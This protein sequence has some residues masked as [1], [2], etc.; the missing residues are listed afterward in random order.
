MKAEIKGILVEIVLFPLLLT[1]TVLWLI[2]TIPTIVLT[3]ILS[4]DEE[5]V[6]LPFIGAWQVISLGYYFTIDEE[7]GKVL[8]KIREENIAH[9]GKLEK[10]H[11]GNLYCT[12]TYD[13]SDRKIR[14]AFKNQQLKLPTA[15]TFLPSEQSNVGC[16]LENGIIYCNEN[17][18]VST[19]FSCLLALLETDLSKYNI[20][21]DKIYVR[22]IRFNK[23]KEDFE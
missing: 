4:G 18:A 1:V 13:Y 19:H 20:E 8:S 2:F 11:I 15:N 22:D 14:K 17:T 7:E 6:V 10:T 3:G 9:Y 12:N 16:I 5:W 23:S 21:T